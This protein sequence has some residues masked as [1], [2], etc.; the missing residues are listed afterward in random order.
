[1]NKKDFWKIAAAVL[2]LI[3]TLTAVIWVISRG[4]KP[5]GRQETGSQTAAAETPQEETEEEPPEESR[6]EELPEETEETAEET[7]ADARPEKPEKET[8]PG[9]DEQI[10]EVPAPYEPP[11][12]AVVS[13]LHYQSHSITDFGKAYYDFIAGGDGKVVHYLPELLEAFIDEMISLKPNAVVIS[14]DITMNGEIE[15]HQELSQKLERLQQAGVQVLVIPGNHDINNHNAARY[16]GSEKTEGQPITAQ[17]FYEFYREFG[18]DQALSRDPASLSYVYPL[19][20]KYWL[21]MLDTCQY[22]P[23]NLVGG[24]LREET[25]RW[26][27]EQFQAAREAGVTVIPVGHHNLLPESSLYTTDCALEDYEAVAN[28]LEAWHI[29]VYISGHLHVQRLKKRG[30]LPLSEE[31]L[32]PGPRLDA[33]RQAEAS[34]ENPYGIYEIVSD[35]V[36]IPPCQYGVIRWDKDGNMTYQTRETDVSSCAAAR[37]IENPDLLNFENYSRE[38]IKKLT[39]RRIEGKMEPVSQR[40]VDDMTGLYADLYQDYYAGRV[41]DAKETYGS[42]AWQW[43]MRLLPDSRQVKE[44]RAMVGDSEKDNNYLYLPAETDLPE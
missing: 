40:F 43:W 12:L 36:S 21:M 5:A 39:A 41:I 15:N 18:C 3:L 42:L 23:V 4:G 16:F 34:G 17:E 37:G 7:S 10:Q 6:D 8:E 14:G 20:E 1:M 28:Y 35:A 32:G 25:L 38:Y 13:D 29:P 31:K 11:V 24:R 2:L 30:K 19:D 26:M 9:T 22:E 33:K 44:M 27:D